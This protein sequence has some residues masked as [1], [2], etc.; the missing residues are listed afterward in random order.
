[1]AKQYKRPTSGSRGFKRQGDDLRVTIDRIRQA[2]LIKINAEK[3]KERQQS[4]ITRTQISGMSNQARNEAIN[5]DIL[6]NLD[7]KTHTVKRNAIA[8]RQQREVQNIQSQADE[9]GKQAQYWGNFAANFAQTYGKAAEGLVDLAGYKAAVM[10]YEKLT[11]EQKDNFKKFEHVAYKTVGDEA[12][13][14]VNKVVDLKEKRDIISQVSGLGNN[15]HLRRMLAGDF[16]KTY[17]DRLKWI[18]VNSYTKDGKNLYNKDNAGQLLLNDAYMY[19][20]QFDIAFHSQAGQQILQTVKR[21]I[22]AETIAYTNAATLDKNATDIKEALKVANAFFPTRNDSDENKAEWVDKLKKLN[23]LV[24]GSAIEGD[25]DTISLPGDANRLTFKPIDYWRVTIDYLIDN[26]DFA[27]VTDLDALDILTSKDGQPSLFKRYPELRTHAETKLGEK[28]KAKGKIKKNRREVNFLQDLNTKFLAPYNADVD[29]QDFSNTVLNKAWR[30]EAF[31]FLVKNR[32]LLTETNVAASE[33]G[34]SLMEIIM[35]NPADYGPTEGWSNTN[36]M[37]INNANEALLTADPQL[38]LF[39]LSQHDGELPSQY[40]GLHPAITA[41]LKVPDFNETLDK[42][43]INVFQKELPYTPVPGDNQLPSALKQMTDVARGRFMEIWMTKSDVVDPYERFTQ[44][45]TQLKEEVKL[46]VTNNEGLFAATPNKDAR[47]NV[48]YNFKILDVHGGEPYPS[49]LKDITSE[50]NGTNQNDGWYAA[51]VTTEEIQNSVSSPFDFKEGQIQGFTEPYTF[52]EGDLEIP[53]DFY[54]NFDMAEGVDIFKMPEEPL[55]DS[56]IFEFALTE[57][58]KV[59]RNS[60]VRGLVDKNLGRL[61]SESNALFLLDQ[62]Q[63]GKIDFKDLESLPNLA[64]FIKETKK[65]YP[66]MSTKNIMDIVLDSVY[67][68]GD[69]VWKTPDD[70]D[71]KR[72]INDQF[73]GVVFPMDLATLCTTLTGTSCKGDRNNFSSLLIYQ[74]KQ[75]GINVEDLFRNNILQGVK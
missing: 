27:D 17:P 22:T 65:Y 16:I 74:L 13:H 61:I 15:H 30:E 49:K 18:K 14:A 9:A 59:Q 70:K 64:E 56:E 57:D 29:N 34:K 21:N 71:G 55:K 51:P 73:E 23:I 11:Q 4:E 2:N 75:S 45:Q 46:G 48:K 53:T 24:Q 37:L 1:M 32:K 62:I 67:R 3:E 10:A 33:A 25:N 5:R 44:T 63:R 68:N 31:H 72:G 54:E 52:E 26:V 35:Y 19:M 20:R 38:A 43:L 6:Q 66:E 41:A 36:F 40:R 50:I 69:T 28:L 60:R 8:L 39:Y 42:F 7:D 47:E 58:P 12:E